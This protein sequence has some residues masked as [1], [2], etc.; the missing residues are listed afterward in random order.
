MERNIKNIANPYRVL[1]L[2]GGGMR[3]LYT[4][5][6]LNSL[7]DRFGSGDFLDIGKGFDL[8]VGTSTGGILACALAAGVPINDVINLYKD[9]G[10]AIFPNPLPQSKWSK[11]SWA[12][13]NFSNAANPNDKLKEELD[14]IFGSE[15]VGEVFKRRG[16]GLCIASINFA[17]HKAR[18]FKTAHDPKKSAD[19]KRL[20]KE[21][22]LATSA[23]PMI[24]PVAGIP[25]PLVK[26]ELTHFVDG[27]LWAN[28]PILIALVEALTMSGDRPI[29]IISIGTCPPPSG[30]AITQD[31]ANKGV[32]QWNFG[33]KA[34]E[35]SM[36]AQAS[37]NQ[38]IATFLADCLSKTGKSVSLTRLEQSPPSSEQA[39][40]LG[41][42]NSSMKACS[43]LIQLGNSDGL[44]IYGKT[45]RGDP[46]Y[47]T[48][49][50]IFQSMPKLKTGE[51]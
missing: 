28:N 26:D 45:T 51:K 7:S 48:L 41:L 39:V 34:L 31:E 44:E 32:S 35:L 24:L 50:E 29:E 37:G 14:R 2:D 36:D 46:N 10:P 1:S 12:L 23:A 43:T 49:P 13:K 42:D 30:S 20:L 16:I 3:G 17:T 8:I 40:L 27:G 33:L 5:A 18:V 25:D 6:V 19:D 22:C 47:K 9:K 11:L 21:V 4:A 38:F 15:T